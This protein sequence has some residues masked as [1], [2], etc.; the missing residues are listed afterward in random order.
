MYIESLKLKNFRCF[1]DTPL[2]ICMNSGVTGFVGDNG[3]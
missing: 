1:G 2:Q 3:E